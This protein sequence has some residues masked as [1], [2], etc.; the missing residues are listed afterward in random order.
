[1]VL[2][3]IIWGW[4]ISSVHSLYA[5]RCFRSDPVP[6][7]RQLQRLWLG[8][9]ALGLGLAIGQ[10]CTGI[11]RWLCSGSECLVPPFDNIFTG[12]SSLLAVL[13]TIPANR[14][15]IIRRLGS[16]GKIGSAEQQAASVASLLGDTSV[17]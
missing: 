16:L 10:T 7:R 11:F 14:G 15:R 1:M 17:P 4:A 12:I 3:L 5:H 13:A 6:P 8:L 2:A 9:Y